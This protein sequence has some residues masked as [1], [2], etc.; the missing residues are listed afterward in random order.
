MNPRPL[1]LITRRL[2][3]PHCTNRAFSTPT[4]TLRSPTIPTAPPSPSPSTSLPNP[5]PSTPPPRP[6]RP[7]DASLDLVKK[8]ARDTNVHLYD[9]VARHAAQRA[10]LEDVDKTRRA[11]EL[12]R[13]MARKWKGGDVY[14]PHDLS[15]VEMGKWKQRRASERDAFDVL[16]VDPVGEYKNFSMMSEYMTPMGRIKHRR[17]T[18]LRAVNQ[19]KI[20]KAIRRAVGMGL[21]PSV[22]K[23][24]EVLEVEAKARI[25][26]QMYS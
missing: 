7:S 15:S 18:G 19:R 20:A 13:Q 22:H 25:E 8:F 12:E 10:R 1:T 21:I 14:A 16:G 17:E 6:P 2:T 9:K 24:P 3:Q 23:H 11:S 26:K 5:N 4:S